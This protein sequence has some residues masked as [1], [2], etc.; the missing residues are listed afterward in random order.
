MKLIS[1]L[2]FILSL[3]TF[4]I[5]PM[6]CCFVWFSVD[7]FTFQRKQQSYLCIHYCHHYTE[8]FNVLIDFK[9]LVLCDGWTNLEFYP[10]FVYITSFSQTCTAT[11]FSQIKSRANL[12]LHSLSYPGLHVHALKLATQLRTIS[13]TS[14]S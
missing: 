10:G 9:G 12:I 2:N 5:V 6:H 8:C 14:L 11:N 3:N 7:P 4:I 1:T 13:V